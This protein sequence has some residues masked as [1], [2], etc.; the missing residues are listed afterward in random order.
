M[1]T[2]PHM[3]DIAIQKAFP[4]VMAPK[5]GH[6]QPLASNGVRY[7]M[8]ANGVWREVKLPWLDV[9]HRIA[10]PDLP[11]PYGDVAGRLRVVCAP[12][13]MEL[14]RRFA[15]DAK[16]AMPYEMA[17]ALIWSEAT[18]TWRYQEREPLQQSEAYVQYAEAKLAP[19]EHLVVDLHSHGFFPA[20]FSATD[21]QDDA[22][23]MRFSGVIGNLD[24]EKQSFCLRLNLA[25]EAFGAELQSDGT[26]KVL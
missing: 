26:L 3:L 19:G 9:C 10:Q 7:V 25:G 14:M 11:L 17:A 13:P 1:T 23:S 8:A 12:I 20:F 4:T 2:E 18:D 6:L 15:A 21:D 22:G 24:Q 5:F 16:R